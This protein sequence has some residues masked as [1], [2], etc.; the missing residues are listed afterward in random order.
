[1]VKFDTLNNLVYKHN[2]IDF[3]GKDINHYHKIKFKKIR[4][5]GPNKDAK[6]VIYIKVHSAM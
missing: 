2:T 4:I 3:L 1:M 5:Y 6:E